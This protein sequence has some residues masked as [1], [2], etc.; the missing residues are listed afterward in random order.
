[1]LN[2]RI[3]F[4]LLFLVLLFGTAACSPGDLVGEP[5]AAVNAEVFIFSG[6]VEKRLISDEKIVQDNCNGS[7][8]MSQTVTRQHMVQYTLELGAGLTVSAEGKVGLEGIG[9]VGVGAEV[10]THYKVSYGRQETVSRSQTV[11]AA[12]NSHIQ[13]IIQQFEVWETGEVLIVAG[14]QNQRLPYSF[15]RDFSIEAVA[16]ANLGCSPGQAESITANSLLA[17]AP[18]SQDNLM[19]AS[20]TLSVSQI[21]NMVQNPGFESGTQGWQISDDI[22]II[23]GYLGQSALQS[24]KTTN[25]GWGWVGLSQEIAVNPGQRYTFTAY[26]NWTNASQLHMKVV[27]LDDLRRKVEGP[28]VIGGT[29]GTSGQWVQ[30]GGTVVV[31][32]NVRVATISIWHGMKNGSAEVGGIVQIDEVVFAEI[33]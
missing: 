29:D 12:P 33:P 10:A 14:D 5:V 19:A 18:T 25:S 22:S 28:Q 13:H 4:I 9:L 32:E 11:A 24:A 21:V 3:L 20:P 27:W 1:M 23:P 8:E 7:A 6:G 16:P 31:P 2:N 17:S 26:L 15:R 30:R